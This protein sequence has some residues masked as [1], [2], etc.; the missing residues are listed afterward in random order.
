MQGYERRIKRRLGGVKRLTAGLLSLIMLASYMPATN[1]YAADNEQDYL[2]ADFVEP[3]E[4][5]A[6]IDTALSQTEQ[7]EVLPAKTDTEQSENLEEQLQEAEDDGD[8]ADIETIEDIENVENSDEIDAQPEEVETENNLL[9][10]LQPT[11]TTSTTE[12][13]GHF[14][15]AYKDG[16]VTDG[17]QKRVAKDAASITVEIST[18]KSD[19]SGAVNYGIKSVSA[20]IGGEAA[21]IEQENPNKRVYIPDG[22]YII[23]KSEDSTD[24]IDG[25]VVITVETKRVHWVGFTRR[26]DTYCIGSTPLP[27]NEGEFNFIGTDPYEGGVYVFDGEALNFEL[28]VDHGCEITKVTQGKDGDLLTADGT[29]TEHAYEEGGITKYATR[30]GKYTTSPIRT[31]TFI[32]IENRLLRQVVLNNTDTVDYE[33]VDD[34]KVTRTEQGDFFFI[35]DGAD[36]IRFKVKP[37]GNGQVNSITYR[38]VSFYDD[39]SIKHEQ[40]DGYAGT[41]KIT[42]DPEDPEDPEEVYYSVP[43]P[44][45][46]E[47]DGRTLGLEISAN[48]TQ[49]ARVKVEVYDTSETPKR[50]DGRWFTVGVRVG[51]RMYP[52]TYDKNGAYFYADVPFGS[53]ATV[54]LTSEDGLQTV[55]YV[56]PDDA[57]RNSGKKVNASKTGEYALTVGEKDATL[58][59]YAEQ[60]MKLV[61]TDGGGK[62]LTPVKSAYTLS[63]NQTFKAMIIQGS[64]V[65]DDGTLKP[66]VLSGTTFKN[67]TTDITADEGVKVEGG[68][69]TATGTALGEVK[70]LTLNATSDDNKKFSATLNFNYSIAPTSVTITSPKPTGGAVELNYDQKATIK[71]TIGPSGADKKGVTAWICELEEYNY[72][73]G[74]ATF[75]K[76]LNMANIGSFDGQTITID[77]KKAQKYPEVY[78]PN[79]NLELC[80]YDAAGNKIGEDF[81]GVYSLKFKASSLTGTMPTVKANASLSTN[82]AIGLSLTL[83][84]GVKA[85]DGMYYR[86]EAKAIKNEWT[87]DNGKECDNLSYRDDDDNKISVFK[88]NVVA[89]VPASEK[90]WALSVADAPRQLDDGWRVDYRVTAKLV[91][92][93]S[94]D[95]PSAPGYDNGY[96]IFT[97]EDNTKQASDASP[98][99]IVSTKDSAFETKLGLTKKAPSKIYNTQN[100]IPIAVPK[101]SKTTT[102]Q[103]LDRVELINEYGNVRGHWSRWDYNDGD[104][105]S[106]SELLRVDKESG[107][108]TLDTTWK[109]KIG[110]IEECRN[111]EAGK[112]TVVA[113]AIGGS[114]QEARA[115][116]NITVVESIKSLAVSAPNRVLKTYNKAATVKADV[117]YNVND[118]E[119]KPDT[120]KVTWSLMQIQTP[121]TETDPAEYQEIPADSPLYGMLTI[122]NGTVTVNKALLVDLSKKADDYQFVIAA[123]AADFDG[124]DVGTAYSDP[125]Q[126]TSEAQVPTQFQFV[127]DHYEYDE[128]ADQDKWVGRYYSEITESSIAKK[129]KFYSDAIQHS[130]ILVLDQYGDPMAATLKLS[131][132]TQRADGELI[133]SKTGTV[134]ITAT[135]T[136]GSKKSKKLQFTISDGDAHFT[137][138]VLIQDA[139]RDYRFDDAFINIPDGSDRWSEHG[140]PKCTNDLPGNKYLYVHVAGVRYADVDDDGKVHPWADPVYGD[141]VLIKH[142]L[143]VVKG[144]TIKAT[145]T[146]D[147]DSYTTYV[148]APSANQ[149]VITLTDNTVDK[150]AGRKKQD[151]TYTITNSAIS[152]TKAYTIKADKSSILN[153]MYIQTDAYDASK[154]DVPNRVTYTIQKAPSADAGKKLVARITMDE[155]TSQGL[156]NISRFI[157]MSESDNDYDRM[158]AE[159]SGVY[160]EVT[161]ENDVRGGNNGIF[162]IDF[163]KEVTDDQGVDFYDFYET[164]AGT[165]NFYVT[166]GQADDANG[167]D[168][169][170]LAQPVKMSVKVAAAKTPS[171]RFSVTNFTLAKNE[172]AQWLATIPKPTVTN[173]VGIRP[174]YET[175]STNS[176]GLTNSFADLFYT[177][178]SDTLSS[179]MQNSGGTIKVR[180]NFP[181][182][183]ISVGSGKNAVNV[184]V[185][186]WDDLAKLKAGTFYADEGGDYDDENRK[187][188]GTAA[189]QTK[190]YNAWVK[191]NCTGFL[192]YISVGYDGRDREDDVKITVDIDQYIESL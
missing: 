144:G 79:Q 136:D 117:S 56:Y 33:F 54:S 58:K 122:K 51:A 13:D 169:A 21:Y 167:T 116:M 102:V 113:Y 130:R 175:V 153:W 165:Y 43:V 44:E 187:L 89:Y 146:G 11:V 151:Y 14:A 168:F 59:V 46:N 110:E 137:P 85:V 119:E 132:I 91:Y 55:S 69:L 183:W 73:T 170:P 121:A 107:L 34:E 156:Y 141:S 61:L 166:L 106:H 62:E 57:S 9:A 49:L 2:A 8:V 64:G 143:K 125:I 109:E 173:G 190:A 40:A 19:Q 152:D 32:Y 18:S 20:T 126:I 99:V 112:Y 142:T 133:L 186:S 100:S 88:Q 104:H 36:K 184:H 114:G 35:N 83:P 70:K 131:G 30:T 42:P 154:A 145:L 181:E 96:V 164:P 90:T 171:V 52:V 189:A 129:M 72:E 41:V 66:N 149:T 179:L 128:E 16:I 29:G 158:Q 45:A 124:N 188:A 97:N 162:V 24:P 192:R 178:C 182:T 5:A 147:L 22:E 6:Q 10:V 76:L 174:F 177:E 155:L 101:W 86:I 140:M 120:K 84:R 118:D 78:K 12:D 1:V 150:A 28:S 159:L 53:A 80:F 7:E 160:K 185:T 31:R 94:S 105:D 82:Q 26:P 71:V 103:G 25:D 135:A 15:I 87:D 163:F 37:R 81:N 176:G 157:G 134:S 74:K 172:S 17:I 68:I 93:S 115:T 47:G 180:D 161:L 127:W 123:K 39:G 77:P 50:M 4:N 60:V 108:I 63:G 65:Q 38:V 111:L 3:D 138:N 148:I 95:D 48:I 67:G 23:K 191:S 27:A 98:E 92:A 139:T 75:K